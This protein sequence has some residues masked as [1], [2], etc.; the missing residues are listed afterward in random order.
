[1]SCSFAGIRIETHYTISLTALRLFRQC[2]EETFGS[3]RTI[4]SQ[5]SA[6]DWKEAWMSCLECLEQTEGRV[7]DL[8]G[9]D[10]I[11]LARVRRLLCVASMDDWSLLKV[12]ENNAAVL[13]LEAVVPQGT[14]WRD[15]HAFVGRYHKSQFET[16]VGDLG[17]LRA[18]WES[19][20]RCRCHMPLGCVS[21]KCNWRRLSG[22]CDRPRLSVGVRAVRCSCYL[23]L[24]LIRSPC[25]V[26][27]VYSQRS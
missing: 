20:G 10:C 17:M 21:Q 25:A 15:F 13:Q 1:M 2:M 7:Y 16:A 18:A 4:D 19:A 26:Y 27:T 24:N 8:E 6:R 22:L 12:L 3:P 23:I 5:I 11:I 14:S 9:E